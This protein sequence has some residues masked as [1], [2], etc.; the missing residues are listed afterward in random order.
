[1]Q[2]L[3][4]AN[5]LARGCNTFSSNLRFYRNELGFVSTKGPIWESARIDVSQGTT[6]CL[7]CVRV[8]VGGASVRILIRNQIRLHADTGFVCH[9]YGRPYAIFVVRSYSM[10]D[11]HSGCKR[12][13][14]RR[15]A[16]GTRGPITQQY[17]IFDIL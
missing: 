5:I 10:R 8:H 13:I 1:M 2:I 9:T 3:R 15:N 4:G 6:T 12:N 11:F 17:P 7:N 14:D 16:H